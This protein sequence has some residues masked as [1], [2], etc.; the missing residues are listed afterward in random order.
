MKTFQLSAIFG[1]MHDA[2]ICMTATIR[3]AT[4]LVS[5]TDVQARLNDYKSCISFYL[6][7]TD[8]L[9]YFLENSDYDLSGDKDFEC[10]SKNSRFELIRIAPHPD[11]SRGKG[12]QEFYILD[13]FVAHTLHHKAL[14]KVTGRYIVRNINS[15]LNRVSL[16]L[17]IDLHQKMKVAITGFF[18]IDATVYRDHI[19]GI[20]AEVNDL[21]GYFIEHAFYDTILSRGLIDACELLPENPKYEG[22]SGSYGQSLHRNKYKMMARS[23]ERKLN[24]SLGIR[25]FLIEY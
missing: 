8:L 16:P 7:E 19:M 17:S 13:Y 1:D 6:A 22:I 25:K 20:Y 4:V 10:F 15:I 23:I 11:Q 3:P 2:A 5:R 9:I 12:F 21:S 14:I 24:R 18:I